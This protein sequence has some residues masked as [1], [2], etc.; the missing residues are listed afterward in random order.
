MIGGR[1]VT[2]SRDERSSSL[3]RYY[4]GNPGL[5]IGID[6]GVSPAELIDD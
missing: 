4:A 6:L 5:S 2:A 1:L 3:A